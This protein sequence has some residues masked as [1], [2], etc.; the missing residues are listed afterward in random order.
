MT[1]QDPVAEASNVPAPFSIC[2]RV[3]EKALST[4][5][6]QSADGSGAYRDAHPWVVAHRLWQEA[7]AAGQNL[8][9]LFSAGDDVKL[10]PEFAY[11][12]LLTHIDLVEL[13]RSSWQTRAQFDHLRAVHPIFTSI[14]SV[15]MQPTAEQ[16]EREAKEQITQ[17]RQALT[18]HALHPYAIVETP[19][20]IVEALQQN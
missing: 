2:V 12:G 13:H 14:D 7:L 9:L 15:F 17:Q 8:P 4:L 5:L 10:G 16:Y 3:T 20:Y 19:A 11:W 18:L 6:E 1:D